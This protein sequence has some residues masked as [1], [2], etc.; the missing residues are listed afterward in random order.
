[1]VDSSGGGGVRGVV[2]GAAGVLSAACFLGSALV[3]GLVVSNQAAY[4]WLGL[5]GSILAI[6]FFWALYYRAVRDAN[7]QTLQLAFIAIAIGGVLYTWLYLGAVLHHAVAPLV[8]ET[9]QGADLAAA[10]FDKLSQ[11]SIITGTVYFVG[12]FLFAANGLRRG[13]GPRWANW[14]GVVGSALTVFW[15][16]LGILP[17]ILAFISAI[18]FILTWVWM[19]A[20]G[21]RMV[22]GA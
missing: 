12:T 3:N 21:V 9:G 22:G 4:G 15:F 13:P 7:R 19:V 1:M 20:H 18:G 10:L 16:G 11:V 8:G 6:P 2:G 5:F 17:D 14:V